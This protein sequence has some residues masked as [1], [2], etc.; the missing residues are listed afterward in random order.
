M[1]SAM[2]A[3]GSTV[4]EC[5]ATHPLQA[6][7]KVCVASRLQRGLGLLLCPL[8]GTLLSFSPSLISR[9]TTLV[10]R[11]VVETGV[12]EERQVQHK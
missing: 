4:P 8:L 9:R 3:V 11:E 6:N 2:Y 10:G 5:L 12:V 1:Q 7:S